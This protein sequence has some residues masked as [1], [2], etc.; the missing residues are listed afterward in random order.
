MTHLGTRATIVALGLFIGLTAVVSAVTVVPALP[1][2]WLAGGPFQDYTVP[3]IALAAVGLAALAS[4]IAAVVRPARAGAVAIVAGITMVVFELVQI[5]IVGLALAEYGVERPE[6][7][8]QIVYIMAG[9]VLAAAGESLWNATALDR[10]H[11]APWDTA[12]RPR[13]ADPPPA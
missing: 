8:L 9:S 13:T 3:A 1:R 10:A 2:D 5:A 6:S 7:W 4:A 11:P 12:S